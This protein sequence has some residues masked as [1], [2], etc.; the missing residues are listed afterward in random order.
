L[1]EQASSCED[2]RK[3]LAENHYLTSLTVPLAFPVSVGDSG[4]KGDG[5]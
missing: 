3:G 2:G 5:L 1:Y 4:K